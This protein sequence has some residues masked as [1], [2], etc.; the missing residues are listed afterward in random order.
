V[1]NIRA[2]LVEL[3]ARLAPS[4]DEG[5]LQERL[6]EAEVH[7]RDRAQEFEE[8]GL[9]PLEAEAR[10]GAAFGAAEE[11]AEDLPPARGASSGLKAETRAAPIVFTLALI[12]SLGLCATYV[13]GMQGIALAGVISVLALGFFAVLGRPLYLRSLLSLGAV[14]AG[15]LLVVLCLELVPT[16]SA[17]E[18][19]RPHFSP[20]GGRAY[21][22]LKEFDAN[23][24]QVRDAGM[25]P[26]ARRRSRC[27]RKTGGSCALDWCVVRCEKAMPMSWTRTTAFGSPPS[28]R[29]P[30]DFSSSSRRWRRWPGRWVP[31]CEAG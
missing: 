18:P 28:R 2:F 14:T 23:W 30:S 26:I 29:L 16:V 11:Y 6:T 21:R 8:I 1:A 4:L 5:L 3:E 9:P 25:P 20:E 13:L 10:A 27:G 7:L 24:Q 12:L 31:V 19:V 17:F 15:F 22:R